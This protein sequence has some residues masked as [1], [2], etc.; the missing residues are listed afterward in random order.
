MKKILF[1][2]LILIALNGFSQTLIENSIDEFT[3][4]SIKRTS[5]ETV[6]GGMSQTYYLRISKIDSSYFLELKIMMNNTVFAINKD[7]NLML[8]LNNDS[9]ITLK[10]SDYQITTIGEGAIGYMGSAGLGLHA[11]YL[12]LNKSTISV[13]TAAVLSK[14]RIYFTDGYKDFER[15]EKKASLIKNALLLLK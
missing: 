13:L 10:N 14:V 5:W 6:M 8:K 15:K 11:I 1:I 7:A 3:K 9:L 2:I 12:G 4:A